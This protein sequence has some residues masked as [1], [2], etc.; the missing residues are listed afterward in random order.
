MSARNLP[1]KAEAG[2]GSPG[3]RRADHCGA[4]LALGAGKTATARK[5]TPQQR[6]TRVPGRNGRDRTSADLARQIQSLWGEPC[7]RSPDGL[8]RTNNRSRKRGMAG[9]GANPGPAFFIS[10]PH[11]HDS[12]RPVC[13]QSLPG[14]RTIVRCVRACGVTP[15]GFR[16]GPRL[17]S[18]ADPPDGLATTRR[19]DVSRPVELHAVDRALKLWLVPEWPVRSRRS[20]VRVW[21]STFPS[22][23]TPCGIGV[24]TRM[25]GYARYKRRRRSVPGHCPYLP[26]T[27]TPRPS[28][29]TSRVRRVRA[30]RTL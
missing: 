1:S 15:S 25:R 14:C 13:C 20:C 11:P 22:V 21:P 17:P 16:H 24:A 5:E 18:G 19:A 8:G 27:K 7:I 26:K 23:A 6:D 4:P 10:S 12:A 29:N 3:K 30:I 28:M 9:Q 2:Q